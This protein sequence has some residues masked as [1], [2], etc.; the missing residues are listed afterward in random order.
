VFGETMS[1]WE[2]QMPSG[3]LLRSP[4]AASHIGD[5]CDALTLDRFDAEE[6]TVSSRPLPVGRFVAYGRWFQGRT[7]PDVDTRR[8][9]LGRKEPDHFRVVLE[10]GE[11]VAAAKVVVAAGMARFAWRPPEFDGLPR[12]LVS[13]SSI[14]TSFD[15]FAGR[16]VAVVGAGQSAV[17]SAVLLHEAG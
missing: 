14:H 10:D 12:E 1:F 2:R 9:S 17:E 4:W 15:E 5:P 6:A 16:S 7:L 13:H 11:A 8:G 3:M